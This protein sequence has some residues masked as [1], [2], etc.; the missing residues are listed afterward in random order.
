MIKILILILV[1]LLAPYVIMECVTSF[2]TWEPFYIFNNISTFTVSG[3]IL[4]IFAY[5][6]ILGCLIGAFGPLIELD[7]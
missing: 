5:I 2:A 6:A 7:S 1:S 4:T 3:R